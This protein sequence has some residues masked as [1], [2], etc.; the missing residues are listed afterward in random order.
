MH[1]WVIEGNT[2]ARAFYRAQNG[3]EGERRINEMAGIPVTSVRCTWPAL[4]G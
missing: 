4:T 2:A 1:L 3:T